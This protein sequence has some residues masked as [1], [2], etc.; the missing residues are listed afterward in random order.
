MLSDHVRARAENR[1]GEVVN[2]KYRLDAL[3]GVGGMASVYAATHRN[4]GR[5][6]LKVLHDELCRVEQVRSRFL[7]E[8]YIANKIGHV[9]VVRI[10]D[11]DLDAEGRAYLV[12]EMLS[13]ETL[14]A[15]WERF[16]QRMPLAEVVVCADAILDVLATAHAQ[17]IVHRDLKPENVFLTHDGFVKVM[18]FGIARVLDGSGRTRSGDL[19]G[20]PA[21]M[22]PEQAGGRNK[23]I[24]A[25]TDLWALGAVMFKLL[26]GENVHEAPGAQAQ[27]VYAATQH[28]RSI[29]RVVPELPEDVAHVID[30]S[31][32]FASNERWQTATAMRNALLGAVRSSMPPAVSDA[33]AGSTTTEPHIRILDRT[34]EIPALDLAE[35]QPVR[36][37][38]PSA[39]RRGDD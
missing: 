24:D 36:V 9:G 20:T 25:R 18:D 6:A 17:G 15:R 28:A 31:L 34:D 29:A 16:G 11:D 23:D 37:S 35:T 12:M 2:G 14:E 21:F 10:V 38:P 32:A 33:E 13:G 8:G 30:V 5:M 26:S 3:L 1:I 27:L 4:G 19:L 7:R 22:A 39:R